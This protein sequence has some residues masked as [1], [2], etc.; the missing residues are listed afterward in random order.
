MLHIA[1]EKG[2]LQLVR[3]L[4][5]HGTD[6]NGM[7][8]YLN[9]SQGMKTPLDVVRSNEEVKNLLRTHGGKTSKELQS[10]VIQ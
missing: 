8:Y 1:A 9:Y 4:L 10:C 5:E 2:H 7:A 6:V 3:V